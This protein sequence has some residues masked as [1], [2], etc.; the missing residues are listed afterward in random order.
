MTVATER[1]LRALDF[2]APVTDTSVTDRVSM[3]LDEL[4]AAHPHSDERT[5]AL[6]AVLRHVSGHPPGRCRTPF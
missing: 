1:R 6:S 2:L 5:D 4:E 3:V